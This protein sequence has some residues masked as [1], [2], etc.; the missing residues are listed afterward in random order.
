MLTLLAQDIVEA[1]LDGRQSPELGVHV[2]PTEWG[3]KQMAALSN[4]LR[5][6]ETRAH[7]SCD[8]RSDPFLTVRIAATF[9]L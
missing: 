2:L 8:G 1:I 7:L 6:L 5:C 9:N 4:D 3:E